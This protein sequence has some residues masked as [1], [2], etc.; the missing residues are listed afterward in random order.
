VKQIMY[1]QRQIQRGVRPGMTLL[2]LIIASTLLLTVV[3]AVS[4]VVRGSYA[5]WTGHSGD[6]LKIEAA[7]ATLRHVVRNLRQASSVT[8]I[9]SASNTAGSLSALMSSGQTYVWARNGGTSEV[10]FGVSAASNLLAEGISEL[11]FTGYRADGVTAT[12]VVTEI[13]A[14]KCQVRVQLPRDTSATRT[15]SS[16]VWLRAL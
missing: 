14:V 2:E 6:Y 9:T 12:T 8:A 7:Q 11:T 15:I 13:Q 1:C 5:A 4:V 3:T 10:N 16:W